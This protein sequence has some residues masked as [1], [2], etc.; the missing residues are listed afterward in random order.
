M[1]LYYNYDSGGV[2]KKNKKIEFKYII[3]IFLL[4]IVLI[5]VLF[6][7][8]IKEDRK[9]TPLEGAIKDVG[10]FT[11]N[12]FMSPINF[13]TDKINTLKE[14]NKVYKSYVKDKEKLEEYD[15]IFAENKTLR[16]EINYLENELELDE[17]LTE[18]KFANATVVN[19][20]VAYW[21]NTITINKGSYHGIEFGMA[22]VTSKGLIGK[23]IATTNFTSTV[24]LIT[25][26]DSNFVVSVSVLNEEDTFVGLLKSYEPNENYFLIDCLTNDVTVEEGDEVVTSGLSEIFPKGILIGN[27]KEITI[28][29]FGLSKILKV[30]P[31]ADYN[32]IRY[33]SIL[34]RESSEEK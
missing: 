23:V 26:D 2:M 33:V 29:K 21:N 11:Q 7:L 4:V 24:K 17:T 20:N 19:R 16:D 34:K 14:K 22:A 3:L 15:K 8:L 28:D 6:N 18:Y 1:S 10:T 32:D 25:S 12:I 31:S 13:I 27:V 9:L 30:T 5:L